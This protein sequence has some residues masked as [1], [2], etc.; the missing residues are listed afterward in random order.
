MSR[1]IESA[2]STVEATT[3]DAT[4]IEGLFTESAIAM[5]ALDAAESNVVEVRAREITRVMDSMRLKMT[6]PM[7]Q[8]LK[9]NSVTNTARAEIKGLFEALT[10]DGVFGEIAP[11]TASVYASSYWLCFETGIPFDL[12]ARDKKSKTAKLKGKP[13]AKVDVEKYGKELIKILAMARMLQRSEDASALL[14]MIV[15][16]D[17]EFTEA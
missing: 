17:P 6:V 9:G 7:A 5:A 2:T 8:F 10:V 1:F 13:G 15:S 3:F 11:S 12:N 16:I 4:L 14:D